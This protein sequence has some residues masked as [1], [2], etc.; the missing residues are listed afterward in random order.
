MNL[1][2]S[3]VFDRIGKTEPQ[4]ESQHMAYIDEFH[5]IDGGCQVCDCVV[6]VRMRSQE[7]F[8]D[9]GMWCCWEWRMGY[10]ISVD[11]L[12]ESFT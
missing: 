12:S 9:F 1:L 4:K 6:Q 5:G 8:E 2:Y 10:S 11:L 7:V 3:W